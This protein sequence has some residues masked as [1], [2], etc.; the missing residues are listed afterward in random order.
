[1]SPGPSK[2]PPPLVGFNNNVRHQG[3]VFHIQTEDTGVKKSRIVTHLFADGGRILRTARIDYA[4]HLGSDDMTDIVR[5][6]MK[7]QHKTM[8]IQLRSGEL[9]DVIDA[10]CGPPS[11]P[12]PALT[13]AKAVASSVED[14]SVAPA[15][16]AP[17]PAVAAPRSPPPARAPERER[18]LS[19]PALRRVVPSVPPPA[20]DLDLDV[21]SLDR[22]P[23]GRHA[24][25]D[26]HREA[27]LARTRRGP[28]S[29]KPATLPA[30]AAASPTNETGRYAASRP[31]AIFGEIPTA[32]SSIFGENVTA[33]QSLDEV[34]LSYLA[35][36][37][38]GSSQK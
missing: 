32:Q 20:A 36:D 38:D 3:R 26:P 30:R 9:D 27:A 34:I 1:M 19:N 35:D 13:A 21:D 4:E 16:K 17:E 18:R 25:S 37:A 31:A 29:S 8:F 12:P 7:E 15:A 10:S 11:R 5:R 14:A 28:P 24:G 6:L 22:H 33:E 2:P 23:L